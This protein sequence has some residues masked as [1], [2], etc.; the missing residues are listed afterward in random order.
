MTVLTLKSFAPSSSSASSTSEI[1]KIFFQDETTKVNYVLSYLKGSALDC[2]KPGLLD[3]LE[4]P[5]CSD[6]NLFSEELEANFSTFDPVKEAEAELEGLSMQENHQATKYFIKF[7]QL[8]SRDYW[9]EAALLW[10]AY[11][12]LAKW[13][14]H[15]MVHHD[16]PMT[17]S[18]LRRLVQAIDA[19]YWEC[20]A[21]I[22]HET[23]TANSSSNKSEKNNNKSSSN[24]GK[25]SLQAK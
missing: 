8:S 21:E 7:M 22:A 2:F 14:K 4:P 15:E 16:K 1:V 9:G 25:G 5:W 19:H 13:I 18:G 12:S 3:P 10:Q 11:N 6:F 24:K 17:L 23:P 20:K